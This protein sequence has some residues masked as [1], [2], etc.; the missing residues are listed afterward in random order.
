M[1]PAEGCK[2]YRSRD[3]QAQTSPPQISAWKVC[4]CTSQLGYY[5]RRSAVATSSDLSVIQNEANSILDRKF[6]IFTANHKLLFPSQFFP[7]WMEVHQKWIK[8]E[9]DQFFSNWPSIKSGLGL[10]LSVDKID[11]IKFG[12]VPF[13]VDY[14]CLYE[15]DQRSL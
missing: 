10:L 2:K 15:D 7:Y 5:L 11:L 13:L 4:L 3:L 8:T 6:T 14:Q 9:F 1:A 12:F